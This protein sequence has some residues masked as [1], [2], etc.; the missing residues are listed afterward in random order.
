M[1]ACAY[2]IIYMLCKAALS[3]KSVYLMCIMLA[4]CYFNMV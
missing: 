4:K 2:L 3:D 1:R